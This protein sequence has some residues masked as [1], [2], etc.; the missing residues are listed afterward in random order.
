MIHTIHAAA[1]TFLVGSF[2]FLIAAVIVHHAGG[3]GPP[4]DG[5]AVTSMWTF[6]A[7]MALYAL[8]A[9]LHIVQSIVIV[10]GRH[11]P[12]GAFMIRFANAAVVPLTVVAIAALLLGD[13][14][15]HSVTDPQSCLMVDLLQGA[16]KLFVR[17][18][19]G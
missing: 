8:Q 14:V 9:A 13:M 7:A 18:W 3:A 2:V 4:A 15:Y 6:G 17:L 12:T 16:V 11:L 10:R 1:A 19:L 5:L